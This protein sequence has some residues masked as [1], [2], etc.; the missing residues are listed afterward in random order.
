M[1]SI[2]QRGGSRET[3]SSNDGFRV[4]RGSCVRHCRAGFS[5]GQNTVRLEGLCSVHDLRTR[6]RLDPLLPPLVNET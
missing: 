4:P 2:F 1:H 3:F 6:A 5:A